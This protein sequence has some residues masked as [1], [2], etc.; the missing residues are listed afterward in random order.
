MCKVELADQPANNIPYTPN[1]DKA[2]VYNIPINL[3]PIEIISL[4]RSSLINNGL[5]EGES[6]A[7]VKCAHVRQ[8]KRKLHTMNSPT[9]VCWI[10]LKSDSWDAVNFS[11]CVCLVVDDLHLDEASMKFTDY[12]ARILNQ[13]FS[14]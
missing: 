13:S 2:T 4:Y 12:N 1:E 8:T 3:N 11:K 14:D 10:E 7:T 5:V 9:G 6:N